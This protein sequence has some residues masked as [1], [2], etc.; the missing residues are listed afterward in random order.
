MIGIVMV[1][2]F[3]QC[4]LVDRV[5]TFCS[6]HILPNT[7]QVDNNGCAMD[8]NLKESKSGLLY[9]MTVCLE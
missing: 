2:V 1:V 9:I 4:I 5:D 3:T 8:P 7:Y 6:P